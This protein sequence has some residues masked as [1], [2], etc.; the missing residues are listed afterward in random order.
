MIKTYTIWVLLAILVVVMPVTAYLLKG[1]MTMSGQLEALQQNQSKLERATLAND[2]RLNQHLEKLSQA[3]LNN[4]YLLNTQPIGNP[5]NIKAI[6]EQKNG[7]SCVMN[8]DGQ[9]IFVGD[10]SVV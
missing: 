8:K 4:R 3:F 6:C 7:I 2:N 1:Y 5:I 9:L 10:H